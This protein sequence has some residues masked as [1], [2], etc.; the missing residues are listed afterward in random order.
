MSNYGRSQK[1][2]ELIEKFPNLSK[3]QLGALLFKENPLLFKDA[4]DGRVVVRAVT[5]SL[6]KSTAGEVIQTDK[7]IGKLPEGDKNDFSPFL[8]TGKRIGILSDIHIPYHDLKALGLAI[9]KLKE[10]K[11]DT[12]ILDGDIIDCYHLSKFIK[13]PNKRKHFEEVQMLLIFLDDLIEIFPGVEIIYKTGNH[14]QRYENF[15]YQKSPEFLGMHVLS[16]KHLLNIRLDKCDTCKG[17]AIHKGVEC[18]NC[19]K[20][21]I[22]NNIKRGIHLVK[23]KRIIKIGKLSVGHGDEF[24]KGVFSPVNPARGFYLK[25][26]AN[27]LCGD[28]HQVSAHTAKDINGKITAAWSIGCLCDM[29]PLYLPINEWQHGFAF[30]ERDGEEFEVH[31]HTIINGKVR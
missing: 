20:G 23:D 10:Y 13:D 14:E 26:K 17:T 31:N 2:R 30:V 3:K 1:A 21:I 12:L 11:I 27:V 25:A 28:R 18:P 15:I 22:A 7:Y 5:G 4:E 6:G 9:R 29:N 16:W 8:I 19:E 24:G